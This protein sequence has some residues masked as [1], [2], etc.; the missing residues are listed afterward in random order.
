[1]SDQL[2][3]FSALGGRVLLS[4]IFIMSGFGKIFDF[5]GTAGY[6]ASKGMPM[7]GVLLVGAIVFEIVGGLSVLVGYK[8]RWGGVILSIFLVPATLIFHNF[9]AFEGMQGQMEMINFLKNVSILGGLALVFAFGP[10]RVSV[11][12]KGEGE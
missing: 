3:K 11:D 8:A 7:V 1:M 9:W 5:E 10:G 2:Q 4:L 12:M 6:M